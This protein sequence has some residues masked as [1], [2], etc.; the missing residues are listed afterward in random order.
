MSGETTEYFKSYEDLEVTIQISICSLF[1]KC[2][3]SK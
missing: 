2:T 1:N 3:D